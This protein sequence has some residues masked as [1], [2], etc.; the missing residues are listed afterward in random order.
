MGF[1]LNIPYRISRSMSAY[2]VAVSSRLVPRRDHR[3]HHGT[4]SPSTEDRLLVL[5]ESRQSSGSDVTSG[6]P[7]SALCEYRMSEIRKHFTRAFK[8]CFKGFGS[9]LEWCHPTDVSCQ[10]NVSEILQESVD[11]YVALVWLGENGNKSLQ[12]LTSFGH[13]THATG[14]MQPKFGNVNYDASA[15]SKRA[16]SVI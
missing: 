12:Y 5:Y 16:I 15:I 10:R 2:G 7:L 9:L 1:S 13:N 6:Q 14:R 8:D 11:I 3:G 4:Q